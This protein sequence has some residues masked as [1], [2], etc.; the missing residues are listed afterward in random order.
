MGIK[1][2]LSY[3]R[4]HDPSLFKPIDVNIFHGKKVAVD[5]S[6]Y[7]CK[8]KASRGDDWLE[9]FTTFLSLA[10]E[11]NIHLLFVF[12]NGYPVEKEKERAKRDEQKKKSKE[13]IRIL[14]CDINAYQLSKDTRAPGELLSISTLLRETYDK[15]NSDRRKK[16]QSLLLRSSAEFDISVVIDKLER[17]KKHNFSITSRDYDSLRELLD[18]IEV[19]WILA[20]G[21]A[22]KT[23]VQLLHLSVVDAV[24]SEDSDCLAYGCSNFITR[25]N[26]NNGSCVCVNSDNV[27]ASLGM[28]KDMFLDFCILLGTDYN[29]N[30]K[31]FGPVKSKKLLDENNSI[32][33]IKDID[34]SC[35]SHISVRSLF[36]RFDPISTE[37]VKKMRY[38][39]RPNVRLLGIFL[40]KKNCSSSYERLVNAFSWSPTIRFQHPTC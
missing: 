39:G 36:R 19:P 5:A 30:I 14:E 18:I 1:N 15:E 13:R 11:N 6:I 4:K 29:S 31:G 27:Y 26:I 10:M 24:M 23:C 16:R 32:D 34:T 21:E 28:N 8:F 3:L 25:L 33:N 38:V 22:E 12:D 2:L 17:L 9:G 35:L 37:N 20:N 40:R 7:M